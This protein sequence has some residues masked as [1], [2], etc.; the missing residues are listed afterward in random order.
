M[1]GCPQKGRSLLLENW[2]GFEEAGFQQQLSHSGFLCGLN[3]MH[4]YK[5]RAG[6]ISIMVKHLS[7]I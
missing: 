2:D 1:G 3:D 4:M 7:F 6:F 5:G